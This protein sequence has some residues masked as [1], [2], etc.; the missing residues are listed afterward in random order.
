MEGKTVAHDATLN[1]AIVLMTKSGKNCLLVKKSDEK[2]V[3]VI[4]EHDVVTAFAR[5]GQGARTAKVSNHMS[6]D[7]IAVRETD[8]INEALRIMAAHN[9]RHLPIMSEEKRQVVDFLSMM[10]LVIKTMRM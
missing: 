2:A 1:E 9:I 3:G 5:L 8:G 4:S 7:L 6:I 10:D